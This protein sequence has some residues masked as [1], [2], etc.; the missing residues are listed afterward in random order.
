MYDTTE[1]QMQLWVEG[2]LEIVFDN[3]AQRVKLWNPN[4]GI[5]VHPTDEFMLVLVEQLRQTPKQEFMAKYEEYMSR[6]K[7]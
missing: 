1:K 4:T 2:A 5:W 6:W 7:P 3:K